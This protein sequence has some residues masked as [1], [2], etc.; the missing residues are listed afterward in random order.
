M[1]RAAVA[2][3]QCH[4][5]KYGYKSYVVVPYRITV[6]S[7]V[8]VKKECT[9]MRGRI[10]N[11]TLTTITV[12]DGQKAATTTI[13]RYLQFSINP[14]NPRVHGESMKSTFCGWPQL[15]SRKLCTNAY[16]RWPAYVVSGATKIGYRPFGICYDRRP[17]RIA[18]DYKCK[19][20]NQFMDKVRLRFW[21]GRLATQMNFRWESYLPTLW[22]PTDRNDTPHKLWTSQ[23]TTARCLRHKVPFIGTLWTRKLNWM[24]FIR[25]TKL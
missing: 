18:A 9:V 3:L 21:D 2:N 12:R 14:R 13:Q 8:L 16:L 5:Q 19:I 15:V 10:I 22:Y 24:T 6:R 1:T 7:G 23:G 17:Q 20:Y 25:T 4:C 11:C